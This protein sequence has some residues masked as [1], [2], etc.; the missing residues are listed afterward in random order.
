MTL[1]LFLIFGLLLISSNARDLEKK[2]LNP[3]IINGRKALP[4]ELPYQVSLQTTSNFPFCGGSILNENYVL[5]AAHC[6]VGHNSI[7]MKVVAGTIDL[8]Q[9]KSTYLVDKII[10]HIEYDPSRSWKNDIALIKVKTP[11]IMSNEIQKIALPK[12]D[13]I[14]RENE[15]AL[16]SGWGRI[17]LGGPSS[18]N[19]QLV[20][21]SI[22]SQ[23]VCNNIYQ[24]L[25]FD[26][27][28]TQ[29]CAYDTQL[30]KGACHGD[31][32]GPLTVNG[33]L[34]VGIVSWSK[35]CAQI[36]YPSVYTRVSKFLNWIEKNAI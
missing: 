20:N 36:D 6:V 21:I 19:L 15:K 16:V 18:N 35:G 32:G 31:S 17:W 1:L 22:A 4:G 8:L 30:K 33:S 11:F 14:V 28:N 3:R 9:P 10:S 23:T 24:P 29:I 13:T 26:I 2:S 12:L 34:Q 27:Y 5:T 7:T 25:G